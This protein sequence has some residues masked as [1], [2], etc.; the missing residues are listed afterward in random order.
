MLTRILS[1]VIL[2]LAALS[3]VLYAKPAVY[4]VGIGIIGTGC[5]YEY[6]R[7]M[8]AIDIRTRPWFLC[9]VF[10]CLIIALYLKSVP[11]VAAL[12]LSIILIVISAVFRKKLSVKERSF[13]MMAETMGIFYIV[14]CLY[15]AVA[16]RFAFGNDTGLQWTLLL[17]LVTW[18]GDS[19]ALIAGRKIGKR[20]L[21]P[22]LSPKKT[23]EGSLV[24][25]MAGVGIAVCLKTVLFKDLPLHHVVI[26]AFLLGISGQIGDLAESMIKR[27]AGVKDSSK[28]I[29]GH[30]GVL[31]RMDSLLLSIP[32]LYGYLLF[33]YH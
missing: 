11:S 26:T 32:V 23:K 19:F 30:G 24:G 29:P 1:A 12:S 7:I 27:T 5:L 21:A 31:D 18:G 20:P 9:C 14:L 13:G 33:L 17:L 16:V 4:L 3:T 28:L 22:V 15:P 10:W 8:H 6:C 25:L 2:I